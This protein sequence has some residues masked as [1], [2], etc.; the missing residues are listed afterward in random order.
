MPDVSI[1]VK[2]G[3]LG[4][5]LQGVTAL[6]GAGG[7][8]M[9]GAQ[10]EVSAS[11]TD[12]VHA[13]GAQYSAQL[14]GT[15]HFDSN[16]IPGAPHLFTTLRGGAGAPPTAALE[17]FAGQIGVAGDAFSGGFVVKLVEAVTAVRGLVEHV[18]QNPT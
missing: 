1:H 5:A 15:V 2:I 12:R 7:T 10:A 16:G 14:D 3:D 4:G 13:F 8:G 17:G 6:L 11:P 9:A 18:P